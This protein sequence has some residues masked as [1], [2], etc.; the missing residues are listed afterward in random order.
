M[1]SEATSS[2]SASRPPAEEPIPTRMTGARPSDL[3]VA[4]SASASRFSSTASRSTCFSNAGALVV[5]LAGFLLAAA[6]PF[7]AVLLA[8]L[9]LAFLTFLAGLLGLGV[10]FSTMISAVVEHQA[11]ALGAKISSSGPLR[12]MYGCGVSSP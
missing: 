1:G 7:L 10:F 6:P 8:G 9:A 2:L 3:R 4:M 12:R 5:R 11:H